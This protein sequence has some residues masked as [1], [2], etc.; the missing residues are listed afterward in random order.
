MANIKKDGQIELT[1]EDWAE[2]RRIATEGILTRYNFVNTGSPTGRAGL[3][4]S[5]TEVP[6]NIIQKADAAY[7]EF[8]DIPIQK[9]TDLNEKTHPKLAS[10]IV[11]VALGLLDDYR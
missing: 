5:I 2:L 11:L 4:G 10:W 9:T 7:K 1:S 6:L 8:H 3:V